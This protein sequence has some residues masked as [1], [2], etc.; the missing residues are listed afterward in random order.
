[1]AAGAVEQL[2]R[3][4]LDN[5][6]M[7]TE[8]EHLTEEGRQ[9][10]GGDRRAAVYHRVEE[11]DHFARR[12]RASVTRSPLRQHPRREVVLRLNRPA[13]AAPDMTAQVLHDERRQR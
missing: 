9:A 4:D 7:D 11:L 5:L 10:V 12:D 1:L 6:S 2:H 3:R 8:A 13:A